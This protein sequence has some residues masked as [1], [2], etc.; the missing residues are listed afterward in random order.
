MPSDKRPLLV[1]DHQRGPALGKTRLQQ[2]GTG[3]TALDCLRFGPISQTASR[4]GWRVRT[5]ALIHTLIAPARPQLQWCNPAQE[6]ACAWAAALADVDQPALGRQRHGL[7]AANGVELFQYGLHV[8]LHGVLTDIERLPDFLVAFAQGH[9]PQ[10]LP[11]AP[12]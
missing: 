5:R 11:F 4:Y 2:T 6:K 7:R 9:L 8:V 1:S 3:L 12:G 10:D